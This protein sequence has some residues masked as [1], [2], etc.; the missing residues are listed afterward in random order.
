MPTPTKGPRLGGGPAH[1]GA[2]DA[3]VLVREKTVLEDLENAVDACDQIADTLSN[4]AIK[5][6]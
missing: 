3:R 5:H 4:L 2:N 6:G 1:A